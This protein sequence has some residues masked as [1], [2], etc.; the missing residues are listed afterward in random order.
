[1][2]ELR[3][4][5][6]RQAYYFHWSEINADELD[7]KNSRLQWKIEALKIEHE[8]ELNQLNQEN[9]QFRNEVV[10]PRE[11]LDQLVEMHLEE[12]EDDPKDDPMEYLDEDA[13]LTDGSII[14]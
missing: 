4:N 3:N 14:N 1:M 9:H 11:T 8:D 12:P 2:K 5:L 13:E 6:S 7:Q 10:E